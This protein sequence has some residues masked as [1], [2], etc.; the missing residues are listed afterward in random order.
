MWLA[1]ATSTFSC[2]PNLTPSFILL[3]LLLRII[4]FVSRLA[5]QSELLHPSALLASLLLPPCTF[6]VPGVASWPLH[7][8][9]ICCQLLPPRVPP[10]APLLLHLA[11]CYCFFCSVAASSAATILL[12]LLPPLPLLPLNS[13][14]V[15]SS[16][17]PPDAAPSAVACTLF[18]C[19]PSCCYLIIHCH[20]CLH[21][22]CTSF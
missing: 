16:A 22:H 12:Q 20:C 3:L 9:I 19:H 21:L 15:P 11:I 6:T 8:A 7:H 14:V 17:T 18:C 4:S 1:I 2:S 13:V 10:Q 5:P